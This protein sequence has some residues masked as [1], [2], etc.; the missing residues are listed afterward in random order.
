MLR[1]R[2]SGRLQVKGER[3]KAEKVSRLQ[4]VEVSRVLK[5]Y[6]ISECSAEVNMTPEDTA[7]IET[8]N[9]LISFMN[10]ILEDYSKYGDKWEN[11]NISSFTNAFKSW[12]EE[13]EGFYKNLNIDRNSV[14]PWR[15]VGDALAVAWIF[16]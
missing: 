12:L 8:K 9:D 11:Q 1:R 7:K 3:I 2:R 4:G 15:E 6:L 14:N 16:E 13:S 10:H 5:N